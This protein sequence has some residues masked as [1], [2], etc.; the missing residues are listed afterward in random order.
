MGMIACLLKG[1]GK[2]LLEEVSRPRL[3]PGDVIVR[4]KACGICGTDLEKIR[5]ELGPTGILGHEPSGIVEQV[6]PKAE[7]VKEGDRVVAHHHVPCY[8][9][10]ICLNG[11]YTMCDKFKETNLDPCGLAD[12]FRVPEFN[13]TRGALVKLPEQ[14]SF[15]EGA[16]IE[17]TA[18][19][20]RA[21]RTAQVKPTDNILV[22]GLGPT[23]LTQI[24]LLRHMTI[25]KI[26]GVDIV[27]D[28]LKAG[29]RMG[30]DEAI[31]PASQDPVESARKATDIGPDIAIVSTGNER[32]LIVALN[33]VRKGGKVVLFGAPAQGATVKLDLNTLFA[34][35][36]SIIPSYSCVEADMEKAIDLVTSKEL[37]LASLITKQFPLKRAVEALDYAQNSKTALKTLIVNQS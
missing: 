8:V 30:A 14:L 17:P 15:E 23:G 18:C 1:P 26:L 37:D 22:L 6:A 11:D 16:M 2:I 27:A 31:D 3:R 12:S 20:I 19:C 34:R 9:C 24:Q 33:A 13:V 21:V 29:L 7:R 32:A 35:Q 25:G 5:G 36:L 10:Q 28:R 4:M